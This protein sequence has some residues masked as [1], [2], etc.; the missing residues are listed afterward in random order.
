MSFAESCAS[1]K[2]FS[3]SPSRLPTNR[4]QVNFNFWVRRGAPSVSFPCVPCPPFPFQF[5]LWRHVSLLRDRG[6]V[7]KSSTNLS[8][9]RG[10]AQW[11]KKRKGVTGASRERES[12][13]CSWNSCSF[14]VID[15][16]VRYETTHL[17]K[18]RGCCSCVAVSCE[19]SKE[20]A[21]GRIQFGIFI[22]KLKGH[23]LLKS[24]FRSS[25]EILRDGF[26]AHT[27]K[28]RR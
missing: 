16:V 22:E 15:V 11:R 6:A 10:R 25:V 1:R 4:R 14:R 17:D 2:A 8:W 21:F 18:Y 5:R 27:S 9:R 12:I 23:V 13:G 7:T 20:D 24:L 3:A 26:R 28:F 19:R